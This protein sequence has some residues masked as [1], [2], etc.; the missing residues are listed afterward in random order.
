MYR[1]HTPGAYSKSAKT[2]VENGYGFTVMSD[3][4]AKYESQGGAAQ[5]CHGLCPADF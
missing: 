2:V 1:A 4:A 3:G 5:G